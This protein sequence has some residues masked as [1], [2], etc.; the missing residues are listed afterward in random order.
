MKVVGEELQLR[1]RRVEKFDGDF[2]KPL[3][4]KTNEFNKELVMLLKQGV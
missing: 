4:E 1:Q 2:F 3:G